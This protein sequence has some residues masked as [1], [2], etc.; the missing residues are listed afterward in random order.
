M[1]KETLGNRLRN[2][3]S[4]YQCLVDIINQYK[5]TQDINILQMLMNVIDKNNDN[6]N[7]SI[8]KMLDFSLSEPMESNYCEDYE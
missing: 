8:Q 7:E 4:P 3:M 6:I 5:E 1:E 2:L